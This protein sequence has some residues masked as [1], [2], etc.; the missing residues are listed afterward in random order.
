MTAEHASV[1]VQ[2][3]VPGSNA[4]SPVKQALL[5]VR[6]M[7]AKLKA[8]EESKIE[9][10]AVIGMSCRFPGHANT[11]ERFWE[12]L[13]SGTDAITEVPQDRWNAEAWHHPDPE[14][15]GTI[16]TRY[17]GFIGGLTDFDPQFFE[18]SRR[19]AASLDPQQRLL[20]ELTWEALERA[21][22]PLEKVR[23]QPAGVFV[24]LSNADY[25]LLLHKTRDPREIDAYY[26]TGNTASVAAGR[27][28]YFL[29]VTGPCLSVD[30]ACSSSLLATHL[31]CQS[32][33]HQ[34]CNLA[35]VAGVNRILI[36]EI[37]VNF[38]KGHMLA[39]DGRCKTFDAR[40]NGYVRGEGCGVLI[41]KRLSNALADGDAILALIRGSAVNQDG[42]SG[43]L[44]MPNGLAQER[45]IRQALENGHLQPGQ[46]DYIEAH[47]TGTPLGDPIEVGALA[48]VFGRDRT[49]NRPL[50]IGSVKTNFGH[51]EA[52][53][54]M[55]GMI[56]TILALQH[57][58]IPPHLHWQTPSPHINWQQ[59][60]I[61]VPT[62]LTPWPKENQPRRAG[63]SS[64]AFGGTN[65]H[66]ILEEAPLQVPVQAPP[67][68][69]L[70][71][72]TSCDTSPPLWLLPLSA[73]NQTALQALA[74]RY[75]SHL[76][77][78]PDLSWSD[79]CYTAAT[80]RTTF[81]WRMVLVAPSPN[82]IHA[83]E[84]ITTP[85]NEFAAGRFDKNFLRGRAHDGIL[86]SI[87][88]PSGIAPKVAFLFTGMGSHYAGMGQHLYQTQPIFRQ[89]MDHCE[90]ILRPLLER[91]L[92][93]LLYGTTEDTALLHQ[94]VY[95]H[96]ALFSLACALVNLWRSWGI[97]PAVVLGHSVGEYAAAWSAGMFSLEEGLRIIVQRGRLIQTLPP[98]GAMALVAMNEEQL[99]QAI[100]PHADR[101]GLAAVNGPAYCTLS[102][103]GQTVRNLCASF[104]E[105]G[106]PSQ[107]IKTDHAIH[108]PLA[109][110]MLD[111][112][113]EFMTT[114]PLVPPRLELIANLTGKRATA[115][116]ATPGYWRQQ[117]R[118]PVRFADGLQA[119]RQ[120]GCTAFVEM[121]A[122]PVLTGLGRMS[123][124]NSDSSLLWL[125]SLQEGQPDWS[126]ILRSLGAL[127]THG[128]TVNWAGFYQNYPV[129]RVMLP[130]YPFQHSHC[131]FSDAP[132]GSTGRVMPTA[133][134][135]TPLSTPPAPLFKQ[136]FKPDQADPS[137]MTSTPLLS[138]HQQTLEPTDLV[139]PM[140]QQNQTDPSA[141][142]L[143]SQ[144]SHHQRILE[145]LQ[146]QIAKH[147][148]ANP[149][150]VTPHTPLLE[151][152]A[153]SLILMEILQYIDREFGVKIDI[154]RIFEDLSTP[155]AVAEHIAQQLP[156]EWFDTKTTD[157]PTGS[158]A[159]PTP[160]VASSS[161]ASSV[162]LDASS[163]PLD[164]S[165]APLHASSVPQQATRVALPALAHPLP[166]TGSAM[167]QVVL[168]QLEI[169]AQQ[170]ELLKGGSALT[171][172]PPPPQEPTPSPKPVATPPPSGRGTHFASFHNMEPRALPPSQKAYLETFIARYV[173]RT[174]TS[175]RRAEED[176]SVWAD[177]RSLM[178][179]RP[180]TKA[181]TYPILSDHASGSRF[182]DLDGNTYVDLAN[183][184]GVHLFGHN[185][186]FL[187]QA[188]QTQIEKGIHLGPQSGLSGQVARLICE[189]TGMERVA[190]CCTGTETV[191]SAIRLARAATGKTK[192]A[193]FSG[194]YHGHSDGVLV[195]AGQVDGQPCTLPMMPG[196]PPGPASETL[197][198]NYDKPDALEIIRAHA[199]TL[200]A[201]LV[202]P[203]PSR[204]PSMQPRAFLQQ[205]RALTLEL[206][207]PLI[208]DEMITGFRILAGGA[209]AWFGVQA[210]LATYGKILGGGL[211]M[212]VL[213]GKARFIDQVDGGPWHLDDPKSFPM[214]ETTVAGAGTFR[215]HPLALA[216]ALAVLT[217]I[218]QEGPAMYDRLNHL[219]S[220]LEGQLH[221][222]F[223]AKNVPVRIA[224]FGSLFR[225]VQS[226]NFSYTF[227]PLEMD[228]LHYGLI[229][230]GIY[231]W[232]GRTCFIST[233]HTDEDMAR[234]IQAVKDTVEELLAAGFFP[235][236]NLAPSM[237][238]LPL[239]KT[240]PPAPNTFN[241][242]TVQT[243]PEPTPVSTPEPTPEKKIPLS[244]AQIQLW[245]LEQLGDGGALSNL[246]YTNLQLKGN[247]QLDLLQKAAR[248]V[249]ARHEALRTSIDPLGASQTVLPEVTFNLP[250]IDLSH[251]EASARSV[252]LTQ[253]FHREAATPIPLSSP[254]LFRLCVIRL[255]PDLHRLVLAAHHI[256]IDGMSLV[257][258][259]RELF[260]LYTGAIQGTSPTLPSPMSFDSYLTWRREYDQSEAMQRHE[261]FWLTQFAGEIPVL[262]L[263][264]DH[265][266]PALSTYQAARAVLRLEA[267]LYQ[268]L[269]KV[270]GRYHS[271]LFML[272]LAAYQLFLHR[273]TNQDA[274]V[275]GILV[276][277]RPPES[278]DRL[279]GYCSHILP[280]MSRLEGEPLFPQFLQGVR[281]SLLLAM[282]HQN[283][284]FARLIN[285]LNARK[286]KMQAPLVMT[287]FNMDHP[288]E[289]ASQLDLQTEWFPQPIHSLDNALS[290]NVTDIHGELVLEFDYSTELFETATMTRW[291]G[292]F[293]TLLES[294]VADAQADARQ[295]SVQTL[296]LLTPAEQRIVLETWNQPGYLSP[297]HDPSLTLHQWFERWAE[298]TPDAT[299]LLLDGQSLTY[300]QLNAQANRLAHHLIDMGVV[301]ESLV[302]ICPERSL[303][304]MVGLLGILK[305]GGAYVPLDPSH[306]KQRLAFLI[307]D[308]HLAIILTHQAKLPIL[309]ETKA[310]VVVLDAP[311]PETNHQA[312]NNPNIAVLPHD[313][314]YVI[315]TSG[316]TGH[317]K[318]VI[319]EHH[320]VVS[321]CLNYGTSLQMTSKDRV[322]QFQ[323]L[324]FD[325][326]AEEIFSTLI[327]GATLV[328]RGPE[329]W[330]PPEFN[331]QARLNGI[332]LAGL[333]P[334]YL[335][336]LAQEWLK[337]PQEAPHE[338]FRAINVGGE[339]FPGALLDL[340]HQTPMRHIQLWN[341]YGPTEAIITPLVHCIAAPSGPTELIPIGRPLGRRTAYILDSHGQPLPVGIPGELLLGGMELARGYLNQPELT[342]EKFIPDPFSQR[343]GARLYKTGDR[344]RYRPDGV[345]EYLG[346]MD[347]QI[348]IRGIRIEP[349]EIENI[350]LRHETVQAAAVHPHTSPESD[351][352]LVAYWVARHP[353]ASD[354]Q[355][356]HPSASDNQLLKHFLREHLPE[357]MIP[358]H[359]IQLD[360]LPLTANGKVDRHALP[361]PVSLDPAALGVTV[362]P[363]TPTEQIMADIWGERLNLPQMG[364]HHNFF[365]LGGHSL[366]AIQI[367][368]QIR[369][370][371]GVEL[372]VRLFFQHPTIAELAERIDTTLGVQPAD[373][374]NEER[375]EFVF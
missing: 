24:A 313:P 287:T 273:L 362:T 6:E 79:I 288:I 351:P 166:A 374:P 88:E 327:A 196:V 51:L 148:R 191:M 77:D 254:P 220:Q 26:I 127:Y 358:Q 32:L 206:D 66:T 169:M 65:A 94:P 267:N 68:P 310:Q 113:E 373:H 212:G 227:Q 261:A 55:A 300:G 44:T 140:H 72:N 64:F 321:H 183:G 116:M 75:A 217:H 221:T 210:D 249:V 314:A 15:P 87:P 316:S 226:G 184:F 3:A 295:K 33:R 228:L 133:P 18:I 74:N 307:A 329:I 117:M 108:S 190:F 234:I 81:R 251:L 172:P 41:L 250:L 70:D 225:F 238:A 100:Q 144:L 318:G 244:E 161:D 171:M 195:T 371:L 237:N 11:P 124:M 132:G 266:P 296:P 258:L 138:L 82:G 10:I 369:D 49:A 59:A 7:R 194:S 192:I 364:I 291:T 56:K 276:L 297:H 69:T 268:A 320:A 247:L 280:I 233:A 114:I 73:K 168:R 147:L 347:T 34:E 67:K 145:P 359:F 350:L 135:I 30:T 189:M 208:F 243:T 293:R 370:R 292:H 178:G 341:G 242:N 272:L 311:W 45:V 241:P 355:L 48:N 27:L 40:A 367:I 186:P 319:V 58:A 338:T 36:P 5:A 198:L 106:I 340:Y 63:V 12:L 20:L 4:L 9:P 211:P 99:Q 335:Q 37:S 262:E 90:E 281:K 349:D 61:T 345:I 356:L 152:G 372:P 143:T 235:S 136:D 309:P 109:D 264:C 119:A 25:A 105:Q 289:L 52:A 256:L 375:E 181:L 103:D 353:A 334:A 202:E 294:I 322:L 110:P 149:E 141:T 46:I 218:K 283:Y 115:D 232:E 302:G 39:P 53:S 200:A 263:P 252:E 159:S 19:E 346:R 120:L 308:A 303:L 271:T 16:N 43:G 123:F 180:E 91:P 38:T 260:T 348:K 129:K 137:T 98:G 213:A 23:G 92:L 366:L 162:P 231:L 96:S 257:I 107:P 363:R 317:P 216:A 35:L 1:A 54:G 259:L 131:W 112:F 305:A 134:D 93:A 78:H 193:L 342:Q 299:A 122:Q 248:Q 83:T 279:I 176:R 71:P 31:A 325:F 85:L 330:T 265:A 173:R 89:T 336:Q 142:T 174:Q 354:S 154:R 86:P 155:A 151:L 2:Q 150:E 215:R 229:E 324:Q 179:M 365:D 177:V 199:D 204:Q 298:Q 104:A 343:P 158:V 339:K 97:E 230:K 139:K 203:V 60:P 22:L 328:L 165:S 286:N 246:S 111:A 95:A 42:A 331:R 8:V 236:A 222:F 315:Y 47:G 344:A 128:M 290:V 357:P 284:P 130:T 269:K 337:Q 84:Q 304:M 118:R 223:K 275:V 101:V 187:T 80:C 274:L 170:L 282:E 163:V 306:P 185:A 125:T 153:D 207:I 121:G 214:V 21:N 323:A 368:S 224:R 50:M 205:L 239:S 164:A 17:G 13:Q 29:G 62:C 14:T 126:T 253:W 333:T 197:V 76:T 326:S 160:Q 175:R 278:Q 332:T 102:G 209:Q 57:Q 188:L 182:V 361:R 285:H 301:R 277:G 28:S 146:Q 245:T 201:V 219:A 312:N 240:A 156:P 167:E 157:Q 270:S 360:A 352:I 255:E